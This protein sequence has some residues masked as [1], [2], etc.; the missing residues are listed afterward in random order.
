MTKKFD[1]YIHEY[2]AVVR[3]EKPMMICEKRKSPKA[4]SAIRTATALAGNPDSIDLLLADERGH[5]RDA[6]AVAYHGHKVNDL[7]FVLKHRSAYGRESF[8]LNIGRLLGYSDESCADFSHSEIGL[9]CKCELCG[10]DPHAIVRAAE[11]L[12]AALAEEQKNVRIARRQLHDEHVR[13]TMY[14]AK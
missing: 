3:R 13:R 1:E 11:K 6:I 7:L 8:Q 5:A 2:S 9:S 10:G 12:E 14:H 4:Y